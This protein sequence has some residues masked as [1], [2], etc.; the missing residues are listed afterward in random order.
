MNCPVCGTADATDI[1]VQTFDGKSF[2][3]PSCGEYDV[4]GSIYDPGT[5]QC[6]DP[7]HRM[8]ALEKAKRFAKPGARPMITSY[9][10]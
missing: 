3:C 7:E 10:L 8:T 6:L 1:T 9:N 5:L 2:K 4:A